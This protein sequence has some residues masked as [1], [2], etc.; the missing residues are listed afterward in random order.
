VPARPPDRFA[1]AH[2]W[3]SRLGAA[4]RA[5]RLDDEL[6]KLGRLTLL[7][8]DEVGYIP[9]DPEPAGLFFA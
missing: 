9:F 2:E 6:E 3:V 1:T 4:Q 8:V 5:G 7:A